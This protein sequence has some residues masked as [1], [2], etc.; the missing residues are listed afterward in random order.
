[1]K[2]KEIAKRDA[3]LGSSPNDD[4]FDLRDTRTR[5]QFLISIA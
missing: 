1:M 3:V 5:S 2:R 4:R